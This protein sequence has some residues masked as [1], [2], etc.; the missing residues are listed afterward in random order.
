M[1]SFRIPNEIISSDTKV[2][3]VNC[4][5]HASTFFRIKMKDERE[6][7]TTAINWLSKECVCRERENWRAKKK[8]IKRRRSVTKVDK[9]PLKM[10]W[11]QPSAANC[12]NFHSQRFE[13]MKTMHEKNV[14]LERSAHIESFGIDGV[15]F[16][17]FY[18]VQVDW[19]SCWWQLS[20]LSAIALHRGF[21]G[22]KVWGTLWTWIKGDLIRNEKKENGSTSYARFLQLEM[23]NKSHN[24]IRQDELNSPFF[25]LGPLIFEFQI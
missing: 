15:C 4:I 21:W 23:V 5:R 14:Q 3:F 22:L 12:H 9:I 7:G 10:Q 2:I 25:V 8:R 11:A 6:T 1:P 16:N 17:H 20:L 19:N 13:R 18:E 24:I